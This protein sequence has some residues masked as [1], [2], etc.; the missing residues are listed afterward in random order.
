MV[1]AFLLSLLR[2]QWAATGERFNVKHP[3]PWLVWEP[4]AWTAPAAAKETVQIS[5]HALES[6]GKG[7]ALSFGLVVAEGKPPVLHIGRNAANDI[8][9]NDA[10]VSRQHASLTRAASGDW[11]VEAS[12]SANAPTRLGSVDLKPGVPIVLHSGDQL[13]LGD[14]TLTFYL[15]GDF[16]Q[17][18]RE[19]NVRP[20]R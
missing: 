11:M 12:A 9:V 7:D 8:V 16:V 3:H 2:Q 10:T 18:L 17:R 6:S 5:A 1:P 15:H 19:P 20:G 14:V 13:K 4:G